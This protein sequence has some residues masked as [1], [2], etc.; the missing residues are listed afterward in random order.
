MYRLWS[1]IP[2][3]SSMFRRMRSFSFVQKTRATPNNLGA[4]EGERSSEP[5][6]CGQGFEKPNE[7]AHQV[8]ERGK[9]PFQLPRTPPTHI[10]YSMNNR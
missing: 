7:L 8:V 1:F 3:E 6:A 5:S 4:E 9:C 10:K 2:W